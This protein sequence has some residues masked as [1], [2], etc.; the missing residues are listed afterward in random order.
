MKKVLCTKMERPS[1]YYETSNTKHTTYYIRKGEI[2]TFLI[3]V[4]V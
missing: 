3:L 4:N 2:K 1:G